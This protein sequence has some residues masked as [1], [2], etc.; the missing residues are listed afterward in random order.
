MAFQVI[1]TLFV[2]NYLDSFVDLLIGIWNWDLKSLFAYGF[3]RFELR[4]R[5]TVSAG[6]LTLIP[7]VRNVDNKAFTFTLALRNYFSV[8]DVRLAYSILYLLVFSVF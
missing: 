5:I 1:C 7:R 2:M 4:L 6:K 3:C 8:S